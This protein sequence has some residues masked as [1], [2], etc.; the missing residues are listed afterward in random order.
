MGIFKPKV[1]NFLDGFPRN[2]LHIAYAYLW[3]HG[4]P[5]KKFKNS[6]LKNP[7]Q[8]YMCACSDCDYVVVG[9]LAGGPC[10]SAR[11]RALHWHTMCE[12]TEEQESGKFALCVGE[13]RRAN[14]YC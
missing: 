3:G 6:D 11:C 14:S 7:I 2:K 5:S 12:L 1:L 13:K 9:S 4:N 8:N 10:K